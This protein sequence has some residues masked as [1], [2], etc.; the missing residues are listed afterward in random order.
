MNKLKT[1]P[2]Q[3]ENASKSFSGKSTLNSLFFEPIN[4]NEIEEIISNFTPHKAVGNEDIAIK[5]VKLSMYVISPYLAKMMNICITSEEY[6]DVLKI[7]RVTP[8]FKSGSKAELRN[9]RP[10]SIL[11][12]FS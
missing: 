11:S 7:A 10:I 8:L 2:V 5:L 6:P 4:K 9:Y 3:T 12:P 1:I